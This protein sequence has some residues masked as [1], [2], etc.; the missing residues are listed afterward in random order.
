[1]SRFSTT[2]VV[3]GM[4]GNGYPVEYS[5]VRHSGTALE[6]DMFPHRAILIGAILSMMVLGD[7]EARTA[8]RLDLAAFR[9]AA[10]KQPNC[11]PGQASAAPTRAEQPTERRGPETRDTT[12][13]HQSARPQWAETI[14]GKPIRL[15]LV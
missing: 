5:T 4:C 12:G 13:T 7:M 15:S 3:L 2:A 8:E 6:V 1:Y 10:L 14:W 11:Y 9:T